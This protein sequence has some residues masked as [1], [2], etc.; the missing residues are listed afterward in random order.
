MTHQLLRCYLL[1]P[2]H[3]PVALWEDGGIGR[4]VVNLFSTEAFVAQEAALLRHFFAVQRRSENTQEI[5]RM[6]F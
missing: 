3:C 2:A 5:K 6:L 4:E 1:S